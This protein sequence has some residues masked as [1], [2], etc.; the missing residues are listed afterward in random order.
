M[1]WINLAHQALFEIRGGL[2]FSC[3]PRA[4]RTVITVIIIVIIL[5]WMPGPYREV[6][7][8]LAALIEFGSHARVV[9]ATRP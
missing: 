5:G 3:S 6:L 7:L 9:K 2:T 8:G 1:P 4:E